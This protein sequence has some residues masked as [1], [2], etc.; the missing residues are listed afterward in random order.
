MHARSAANP[1]P[2][3]VP[4]FAKEAHEKSKLPGPLQKGKND[5]PKVVELVG[6]A[7][8]LGMVTYERDHD[9]LLVYDGQHFSTLYARRL[10]FFPD[11]GCF[12][13]RAGKPARTD[14]YYIEWERKATAFALRGPHLLLFSPGY[15]EV[16]NIDTGKLFRMVEVNELRLLRSGLT[17]GR[18]LVGAMTSGTENDG[19]RTE[20]LVELVYRGD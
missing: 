11:L 13:D 6:K 7:S 12:V 8:V 16:R 17:E 19:S 5:K 14:F 3:V 10:T 15:I 18:L 9:F 2:K 4:V 1:A 20:K